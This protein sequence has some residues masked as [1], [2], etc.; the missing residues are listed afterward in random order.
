MGRRRSQ[1][2]SSSFRRRPATHCARL[3]HADWTIRRKTVE[4]MGEVAEGVGGKRAVV[5]RFAAISFDPEEEVPGTRAITAES[6]QRLE[7][8]L[9]GDSFLAHEVGID[10]ILSESSTDV[11]DAEDWESVFEQEDEQATEVGSDD[12][13]T[14]WG[15]STT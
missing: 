12:S 7:M 9:D 4:A 14:G 1:G 10:A 2:P 3:Q 5:R 6:L 13:S 8:G 11:E 15:S